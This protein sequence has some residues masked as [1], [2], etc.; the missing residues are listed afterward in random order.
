MKISDDHVGAAL[1]YQPQKIIGGALVIYDDAK[2]KEQPQIRQIVE[3][4][5]TKWLFV[6][7]PLTIKHEVLTIKQGPR[8]CF[9]SPAYSETTFSKLII[10]EV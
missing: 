3:M 9:L 10:D 4:S 5:E 7:I 1:V 8:Y 6:F 2:D